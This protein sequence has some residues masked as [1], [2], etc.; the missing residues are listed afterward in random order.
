MTSRPV[1]YLFLLLGFVCV[2]LAVVGIAL[3]ILP[4]TPFLLLAAFFFARSSPR[5]YRWLHTN[6]WFGEYLTNYPKAGESRRAK[7]A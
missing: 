3:P 4:T 1:R 2:A 7:R 6:R 5:V